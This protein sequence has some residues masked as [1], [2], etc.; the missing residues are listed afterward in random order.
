MISPSLRLSH[1]HAWEIRHPPRHVGAVD[2][3]AHEHLAQSDHPVA[4]DRASLVLL[5]F[6]WTAMGSRSRSH[7]RLGIIVKCVRGVSSLLTVLS[8]DEPQL[9][10]IGFIR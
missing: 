4:R 5:G 8:V 6:V 10:Q 1:S 3:R 7:R 2:A 9:D